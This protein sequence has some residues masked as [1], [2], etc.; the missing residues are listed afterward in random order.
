MVPMW[1]GQG[2]P[3]STVKCEIDLSTDSRSC[4]HISGPW[5]LSGLLSRDGGTVVAGVE[6]HVCLK[7]MC[8]PPS[9]IPHSSRVRFL[10]EI[11][12]TS[13]GV[14]WK[15]AMFARVCKGL[16]PEERLFIC[17]TLWWMGIPE[18]M[19]FCER[20]SRNPLGELCLCSGLYISYNCIWYTEHFSI[21]LL[22][23]HHVHDPAM[24]GRNRLVLSLNS[25]MWNAFVISLP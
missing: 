4:R 11:A 13:F 3:W 1:G 5:G 24:W 12:S 9:S 18:V 15:D 2:T 19:P 7:C 10:A 20:V 23:T 8:H 14:P 6:L 16:T 17:R 21:V 22:W 25:R